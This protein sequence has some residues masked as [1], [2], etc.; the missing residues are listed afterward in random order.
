MKLLGVQTKGA[1]FY[2]AS[3][4]KT[5]KVDEDDAENICIYDGDEWFEGEICA[6]CN[7]LI[8]RPESEW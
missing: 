5:N 3:C 2:C 7:T 1:K 4:A 8:E 6:T